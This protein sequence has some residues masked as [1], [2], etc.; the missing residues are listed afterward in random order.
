MMVV[1]NGFRNFERILQKGEF[2]VGATWQFLLV[3]VSINY[4]FTDSL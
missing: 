3:R 1:W 2:R 4:A